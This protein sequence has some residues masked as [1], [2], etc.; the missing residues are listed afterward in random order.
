MKRAVRVLTIAGSDCSGGAGIQADLKTITVLGG[1]GMSVVTAITVQNSRGVHDVCNVPPELVAAQFDAVAGDLGVDAAKTGM[2]GS[3]EILE[4]VSAKVRQYGIEKLVV[5][6]VVT[7]TS[8]V[9]LLEGEAVRCLREELLPLAYVATPNIPEAELISG[10]RI[11]TEVQMKEAARIICDLG[12]R[13]VVIKGGHLT[14]DALDL[15]YD[16]SSFHAFREPRL[17]GPKVHGT[18]CIFSAAL[19]TGLAAGKGAA[20]AVEGAK[21]YVTEAIRSCWRLGSGLGAANH[22]AVLAKGPGP[23]GAEG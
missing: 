23:R 17:K 2:L 16:G 9:C 18:G 3:T 1:F 11:R 7:A 8:G 19:A 10:I 4:V 22:L 14:G 5:D 15:F 6:P 20:E 12:A 13:G 21:R